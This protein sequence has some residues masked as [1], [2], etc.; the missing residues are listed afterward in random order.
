MLFCNALA[1][2]A[3]TFATNNARRYLPVATLSTQDNVEL[4][5][6]LKS[7]FK[8]AINWNKYQPKQLIQAQNPYFDYKTDSDFQEINRTFG[9]SFEIIHTKKI[10]K[11]TFF[12]L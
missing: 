1:A 9:L 8:R 10:I 4:F 7:G 2:Q 6:Q 3:K 11:D 12:Y 5:E